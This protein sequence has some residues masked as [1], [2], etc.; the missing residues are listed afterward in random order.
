MSLD[1]AQ[2]A[3]LVVTSGSTIPAMAPTDT[4]SAVAAANVQIWERGEFVGE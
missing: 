1:I 3:S 2:R 4:S